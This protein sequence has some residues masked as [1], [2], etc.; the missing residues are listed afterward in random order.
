[1]QEVECSPPTSGTAG[2]SAAMTK[3]TQSKAA[4]SALLNLKKE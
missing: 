1:M 3:K 4:S 2:V